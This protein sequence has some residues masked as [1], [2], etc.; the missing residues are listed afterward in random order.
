[1]LVGEARLTPVAKGAKAGLLRADVERRILVRWKPGDPTWITTAEVANVQPH[2]HIRKIKRRLAE[3]VGLSL[4]V[5]VAVVGVS[6][7]T[8]LVGTLSVPLR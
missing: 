5:V 6:P 2:P 4:P 8:R 7:A 1:M 3:I